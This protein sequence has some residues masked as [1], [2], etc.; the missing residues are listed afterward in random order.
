MGRIRLLETIAVPADGTHTSDP[1]TKGL[2]NAGIITAQAALVRG[3]GGTSIAL[4]LQTSIDNGATW[5]DIARFDFAA[6]SARRVQTISAIAPVGIPIIPTDAGLAAGGVIDGV[7]GDMVRAKYVV[8]GSYASSTLDLWLVTRDVA[9]PKVPPQADVFKT[10]AEVAITAASPAT[11]WTP[12][13]G[14]R[15]RLLGYALWSSA[16]ARFI[17][18]DDT[19]EILRHAGIVGSPAVSS[20]NLGKGY[21][22]TAAGNALKLDV[23]TTGTVSGYVFGTEE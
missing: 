19:T 5:I 13:S 15:F 10:I 21:L 22:S 6:A 1:V 9:A 16:S 11:V 4:Y 12:A 14:K 20:P 18:K 8:S 17:L 2:S 7:L 23:T 3:S